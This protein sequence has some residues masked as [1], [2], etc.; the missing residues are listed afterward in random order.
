MKT[1]REE[2]QWTAWP[3]FGPAGLSSYRRTGTNI[4]GTPGN[5][6]STDIMN[7][8][9]FCG[10]SMV[11]NIYG[12]KG[13]GIM[14]NGLGYQHRSPTIHRNYFADGEKAKVP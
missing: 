7:Y 4:G 5:D 3:S 12:G 10:N 13:I 2:R 9:G 6:R 11:G 1:R 14:K 8:D